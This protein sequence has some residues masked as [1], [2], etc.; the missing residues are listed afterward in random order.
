MG[1]TEP[2]GKTIKVWGNEKEIIGVAGDFH[3]ESLYENVNP[4]LFQ[5]E[6]R[7]SSMMAKIK[8]GTEREVI[9]RL[10]DLYHQYNPGL[11]FDYRFL[12]S[13][14][15]SLYAEEQR[16]STL[17][18]YSAGLAILIS[19]LGLFGLATFSVQ[20]RLKEIGIRKVLGS[21]DFGIIRLLS[22][23][24]TRILIVA[25]AIALPLSFL[26][27][28]RWLGNFAYHIELKWWYFG[29]AGLMALIIAWISLGI[30]TVKAA[31]V[32][33]TECLKEE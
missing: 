30:Q 18:K 22:D 4:C 17:S 27:T 5:L 16:V 12:D 13:D 7:S 15:Q 3:Y 21:S 19:C 6:P 11:A 20:K 24:F 23:D 8:A 9:A 32:N 29:L 28:D 33:P 26:I 25:I 10:E 1:I 14:Y 2:V 31:V